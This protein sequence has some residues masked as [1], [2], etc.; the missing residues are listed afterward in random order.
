[1]EAAKRLRSLTFLPVAG[2][3]AEFIGF[4]LGRFLRVY[5]GAAGFQGV[6]SDEFR[7][8]K[9]GSFCMSI[10]RSYLEATPAIPQS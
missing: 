2:A 5:H 6:Q 10:L 9:S 8:S 7:L 4:V 1:M 3:I